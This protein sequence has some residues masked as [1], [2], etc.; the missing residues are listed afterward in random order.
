MPDWALSMLPGGPK[1]FAREL[2]LAAVVKWY[3]AGMLSQAKA[4][5][6]AELGRA[7]FLRSLD[8]FKVSPFQY[9]KGD[10]SREMKE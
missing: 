5:E 7:S 9:D 4:A 3:E 6:L 1:G 2:R 10:L 8:R